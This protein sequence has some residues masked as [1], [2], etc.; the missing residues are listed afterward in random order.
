MYLTPLACDLSTS[1]VRVKL[2]GG[3]ISEN[4]VPDGRPRKVSRE[5]ET[6]KSWL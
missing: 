5:S 6:L 3:L 2:D 4:E 1:H